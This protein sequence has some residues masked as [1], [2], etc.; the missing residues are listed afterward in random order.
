MN[1]AELHALYAPLWEKVPATKPSVLLGWDWDT[2]LYFLRPPDF[3][4]IAHS[5]DERVVAANAALC[6]VAVEDWL[7]HN[8]DIRPYRNMGEDL[9]LYPLRAQGDGPVGGY[10]VQLTRAFSSATR[11]PGPTIHH[12]LVAAALAVHAALAPAN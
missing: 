5:D 6:R 3:C 9:L 2:G 7:L 11:F 1:A 4:E 10:A 8:N 12:T